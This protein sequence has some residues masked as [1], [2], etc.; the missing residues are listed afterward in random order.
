MPKVRITQKR[1]GIRKAIRKFANRFTLTEVWNILV[2]W[3]I[4]SV[5]IGLIFYEGF[6]L[7]FFIAFAAMAIVLWFGFIMHELMHKFTAQSYRYHAEFRMWLWGVLLA[8]VLPL[9][10]VP[11]VFAAPGATYFSPD[12]QEMYLDP[13]GFRRRYG[14]ISL[15]GPR[16]NLISG[17]AFSALFFLFVYAFEMFPSGLLA[18]GI[19]VA[20]I[21]SFINF[22]WAVFNLLP[23]NPLDGYKV[24]NWNKRLWVYYFVLSIALTVFSFFFIYSKIFY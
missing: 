24:I 7:N 17:V 12:S 9:L 13:A 5:A 22:Y 3:I 1:N 2:A 19:I 4:L 23:I 20:S 18:F 10:G 15:A 16:T 14:I 11:F 21:G 8:L 6:G